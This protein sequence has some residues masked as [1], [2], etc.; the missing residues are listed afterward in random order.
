GVGV[1]G[2]EHRRP[3]LGDLLAAAAGRVVDL[4]GDVV[5][6]LETGTL[7]EGGGDEDDRIDRAGHAVEG[8]VHGLV[9]ARRRAGLLVAGMHDR[10]VLERVERVETR[11]ADGVAALHADREE[12]EVD[13]LLAPGD[14]EQAAAGARRRIPADPDAQMGDAREI[15]GTVLF[16]ESDHVLQRLSRNAWSWRFVIGDRPAATAG[17]GGPQVGGGTPWRPAPDA[18]SGQMATRKSCGFRA[19]PE[20]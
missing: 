1:L 8:H 12:V 15:G 6:L 3:D 17:S 14:A 5:G 20:L 9:V 10:T 7:L 19:R 13:A 16:A 18:V 2:A 4:E 11:E